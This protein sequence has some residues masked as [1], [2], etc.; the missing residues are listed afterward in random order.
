M[1]IEQRLA[2]L[3]VNAVRA[4][5]S[6]TPSMERLFARHPQLTASERAAVVDIANGTLRQLGLLRGVLALM[7]RKPLDPPDLEGLLVV[8][9]YQLAFTRA[10]P[11]AVVDHAVEA[12]QRAG[13]PWAKG[14]VNALLR[15]FLREREALL[16]Q[17]R[18]TPQGRYSYPRWWR[19]R[20]CATYPECWEQVLDAG[21]ARPPMALRVNTRRT[22]RTRY[23]AAL[24]AAG[25]AGSPIG[26]EGVMLER[27]LPVAQI[28]GFAD[29]L[30]SVQDAGAQLAVGMLGLAAGQRVLDAFA[31]PGGKSA[32]ILE[33][34]DVHLLALDSDQA[35][36]ERLQSNLQRLGLSA[37]TRC[38]DAGA[39]AQWWDGEPFDRVLAD[40]PCTGSGVVRRHP[41]IKWLRRESDVA[42]LAARA[43]ALL[44]SLWR[45]VRPGGKLL[46]ATC[47]V[48]REENR[49]QVDDFVGRHADARPAPL[50]GQDGFDVQL[51]P[52]ERHDGFYYALLERA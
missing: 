26:D 12:A 19:E 10:A 47:S 18:T 33:R 40:L 8:A 39:L 27:P 34:A 52:D 50:S 37:L 48:F 49:D 15:R 20:V 24:D 43:H 32:H 13:R 6:L 7:L 11:H 29:G 30:V 28:P 23:M 2:V 16:A 5:R 51:L 4:G 3:A 25:I 35:R 17:V 44:D 21:N 45:V 46:L 41:D 36:L 42:A 22:D 9:L 38:A 31:A 1:L 14:L